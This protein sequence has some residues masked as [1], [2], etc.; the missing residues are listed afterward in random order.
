MQFGR[1]LDTGRATANDSDIHLAVRPEIR[2]ILEEQ[3]QHFLVETTRLM[4][5]VEENAVLFHAWRVEVV[6]GTSQRHHQRVVRQ[7]T[8][9]HQQLALLVMQ[10]GK[11]DRFGFAVNI[12]HRPQ[13]ELEVVVTGVSKV[14]Q[15]VYTFIK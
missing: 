12:H 11:G 14:A 1:Q 15:R 3:V 13:L 2:R 10:L 6:R 4:R 7:L 9:G 8:L 5:I